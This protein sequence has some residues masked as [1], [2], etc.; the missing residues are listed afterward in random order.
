MS[1]IHKKLDTSTDHSLSSRHFENR[2]WLVPRT[3]EILRRCRSLVRGIR[4]DQSDKILN[5]NKLRMFAKSSTTVVADDELAYNIAP[6]AKDLKRIN[7]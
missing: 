2:L 5:Y 1:Q 7:E 3:A 4:V 6:G